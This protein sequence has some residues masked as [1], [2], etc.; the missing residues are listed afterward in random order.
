MRLT[1]LSGSLALAALV[2]GCHTPSS[3]GPAPVASASAPVAA[4]PSPPA[5]SS[6]RPRARERGHHGGGSPIARLVHE[7]DGLE[8]SDAQRATVEKLEQDLKPAPGARADRKEEHDALVAGVRAG[9]IDPAKI[10]A[11]RADLDK[12]QAAQRERELSTLAA[13]H[14]ALQPAQRK[15]LVAAA[16]EKQEKRDRHDDGG[17]PRQKGDPTGFATRRAERLTKQLELDPAQQKKVEALVAKT[18]PEAPAPAELEASRAASKARVLALWAAFE[19]DAFDPKKL[20][21]APP[22]PAKARARGKQDLSFLAELLPILR[23]D[24]RERLAASMEKRAMRRG[25][26]EGRPALFD[27]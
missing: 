7:A 19:A 21:A 8:L 27:E 15:A 11:A 5:A 24:Q 18:R 14:A 6:G 2:S 9:R 3:S 13:L 10:D 1:V 23:P 20:E 4:A 26:G 22:A 16:R 12:A 25:G 17:D